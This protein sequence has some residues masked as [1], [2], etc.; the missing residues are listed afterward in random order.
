MQLVVEE[1]ALF[2]WA[3]DRLELTAAGCI[4]DG[5]LC[6]TVEDEWRAIRNRDPSLD[7][8]LIDD[9]RVSLHFKIAC[10]RD[11]HETRKQRLARNAHLVK[12][13]VA[14]VYRVVAELRADVTNLNSRKNL[15]GIDVTNRH[16]E[17][18]HTIVSLQGDASRKDKSMSCLDAEI[19]WPELDRLDARGMDNELVSVNV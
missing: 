3:F 12:L 7:H 19:S 15:E 14:I 9:T 2:F 8:D 18:L 11:G 13:E 5:G 1:R 10:F 17:G 16:N 4:P 6:C